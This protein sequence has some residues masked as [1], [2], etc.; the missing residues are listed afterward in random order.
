MP[1]R[2]FERRPGRER[3]R[4]RALDEKLLARDL[5]VMTNDARPDGSGERG[6][7]VLGAS[8]ANDEIATELPE[9]DPQRRKRLE[10]KPGAETARLREP[11]EVRLPVLAGIEAIH[12]DH[13]AAVVDRACE[14]LVVVKA[15]I[16]TEPDDRG[17]GAV[18][19]AARVT[20]CR[21]AKR[22][23]SSR[24][25]NHPPNTRPSTPSGSSYV[26]SS[27]RVHDASSMGVTT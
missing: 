14:W 1:P 26:M 27:V 20:S 11:A 10:Q 8:R 6:Q 19:H 12:G 3:G 5:E 4:D 17:H 9:R 24:R 22:R 18:S 7:D 23:S 13:V 2:A 16:T 21:K 25:A 15:K